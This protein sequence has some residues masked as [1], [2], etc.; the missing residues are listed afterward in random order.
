MV[1]TSV[2]FTAPHKERLEALALADGVRLS[3]YL[4]WVVMN[5]LAGI[6]GKDTTSGGPQ[7]TAGSQSAD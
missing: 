7:T 4:R 2:T 1:P 3:E 5:H 6:D